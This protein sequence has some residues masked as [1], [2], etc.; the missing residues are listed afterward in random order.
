MLRSINQERIEMSIEHEL[1]IL[2][3]RES[4]DVIFG[5]G[6]PLAAE[7]D[8]HACNSQSTENRGCIPIENV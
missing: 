8:I 2:V 3:A 4:C 5:V 1:E 7:T 6:R